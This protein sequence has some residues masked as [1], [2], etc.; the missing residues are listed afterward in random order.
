[1]EKPIIFISHI[2][3]ER[4]IAA[5][6]KRLVESSFMGMMDVFVSSDPASIHLGQKWLDQISFALKNCAVE[7]VLASPISVRRQWVNFE[8][9]AGWI[10]DVPVIPLCHSGMTPARLPAPLNTLQA[11]MASDESQLKL[12]FP[13]LAKALGSGVPTPDFSEFVATVK[14][15]EQTST[16]NVALE[17]ELATP[18]TS[19]LAAHEMCALIAAAE[20]ADSANAFVAAY[21]LTDAMKKIGFRKIATMLATKMLERKNLVECVEDQDW[22]GNTYWGLRITDEGWLWLEMNKAEL[23][24]KYPLPRPSPPSFSPTYEDPAGPPSDEVP[25]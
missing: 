14:Q 16:Q 7:I 23:D 8:A 4:E 11:A 1:M 21:A 5:A 20:L 22:N 24:L 10:R 15:Y 2:S 13:E 19:G 3:E 17:A 6:L 12:I 9:G 18:E 25:F